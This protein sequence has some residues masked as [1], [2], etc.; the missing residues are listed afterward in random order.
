MK[1]SW[2]STH[3]PSTLDEFVFSEP[4]HRE[5]V[6]GWLKNGS[7]PH[8]MFSG[9]AGTG[10]TSMA[11]LLIKLFDVNRF[12]TLFIPASRENG[13]DMINTKITNFVST[14]PLG[15][16]KVVFLDE[17]DYL[18]PNAQG[19]LRELM[20]TYEDTT[21][22]IFTCNYAHKIIEPLGSR[23]QGWHID[24]MDK[25]EFTARAA[26]VLV[27]E[28]ITFD[29]PTLDTY[30][31]AA[32]P[33]LRKCINML[34]QNSLTGTLIVPSESEEQN[35]DYRLHAVEMF[36][37]GKH[38]EARKLICKQLRNEDVHEMFAWLYDNLELWSSTEQGQNDAERIIRNS[39]SKV[40]TQPY[41]EI[42]LS[43]TIIDLCKIKV[44]EDAS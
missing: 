21:R 19:G 13:I 15:E 7:F 29:L 16:F 6:E 44:S 38:T 35:L 17:A 18:S 43:V 37:N 25:T 1:R 28:E 32:Y 33:D 24:K 40:P 3:R 14:M 26:T 41:P 36:R 10:K 42:N 2:V 20:E 8:V 34:D 9:A 5:Y 4:V 23:L 27:E 11:K 30:V 22:F 39:I 12:D 31:K